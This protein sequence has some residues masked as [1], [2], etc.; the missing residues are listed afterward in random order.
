M[1]FILLLFVLAVS[2]VL[3]AEET[4][5]LSD[6]QE[7][8]AA[9]GIHVILIK[10]SETK[11]NVEI[12]NGDVEEVITEVK[13]SRL[14]IRFDDRNK[15]HGN[16]RHRKAKVTIYYRSINVIHVSSGANLEA[17]NIIESESLALRGSSGGRMD[18][19]VSSSEL[20]IDI[21]SGGILDVEGGTSSLQV[22]VSSGGILHGEDLHAQNVQADASS[23][24]MA[25][26]SVSDALDANASSGGRIR[27]YGQ[28]AKIRNHAS[29]AGSIK[30]KV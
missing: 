15:W 11:A 23:G 1:R 19:Q 18:I 29:S 4:R 22:D 3:K 28:P 14:K 25:T 13:D 8:S 2:Q 27:Y 16:N 24:G 6:F 30:E 5:I 12:E 21:S 17:Q 10:S 9:A 20:S 7:V 26:F